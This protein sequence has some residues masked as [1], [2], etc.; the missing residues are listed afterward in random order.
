[1][2]TAKVVNLVVGVVWRK[3]TYLNLAYLTA[4]LPL[5]I[6][7]FTVLV[8][9]ISVGLST[10]VIGIGLVV[11]LLTLAAWWGLAIFERHLV[12][13]WLNMP[14]APM[15][16]PAPAGRTWWDRVRAA[17]GN[18]VTWKSLAYLFIEFPFGIFAFT[19]TTVLLS[20]SLTALGYPLIYL[21]GNAVYA[22]NP[23]LPA[24][25]SCRTS[26]RECCRGPGSF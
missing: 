7:Y 8:T 26:Y 5:G 24:V 4:T 16:P 11:L 19:A 13:W 23:G 2:N 21:L 22:A 3:Q 20:I 6:V 12:M 1:M 15:A 10:A 18:P 9:G 17:V 14:I 25:R